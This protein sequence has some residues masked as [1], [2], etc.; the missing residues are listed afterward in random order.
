MRARAITPTSCHGFYGQY[1]VRIPGIEFLRRTI[2][3]AR[4]K[5]GSERDRSDRNQM[6]SARFR[7]APALPFL[8]ASFSAGLSVGFFI[9]GGFEIRR[10]L[11]RI[12]V[13]DPRR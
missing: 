3:V 6:A 5:Q 1:L 2:Y 8:R 12:T 7:L 13:F 4:E 11:S 10:V 9:A